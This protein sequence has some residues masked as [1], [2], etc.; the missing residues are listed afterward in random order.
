[1][2]SNGKKSSAT[3]FSEKI[4]AE[5]ILFYKRRIYFCLLD[6]SGLIDRHGWGSFVF[7]PLIKFLRIKLRHMYLNSE[8][9]V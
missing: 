9:S 8:N 3:I 2:P 4:F 5:H 7:E 6:Y 1:V